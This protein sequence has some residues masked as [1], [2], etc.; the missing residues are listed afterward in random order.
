MRLLTVVVGL[1]TLGATACSGS[2]AQWQP[3]GVQDQNPG[4]TTPVEGAPVLTVS[5]AADATNVSPGEP[6]TVTMANGTLESVT[7]TNPDN[8]AVKGEIDA[9]KSTWKL[10][11]QLGYNKKYTLKI[12]AVGGDGSRKEET[13]S[14]T[15]VKPKNLTLPYLRANPGQLLD[16]GKFGTGQPIVAW[17][18][19]AIT[20]KAAAE[21]SLTVTTSPVIEGAWHWMDSHE[22]HWRP[23]EHWPKDTTVTVEAKVYGKDLGGGLFGQ[24]DVTAKFTIGRDL[25]LVADH[26]T[27]HMKVY[28]DGVQM[29]SM[30]GQNIT[31][32]IPIS[33]GKGGTEK[34]SNGQIIDFRTNSGPH[35]VMMKYDN[36]RMTSASFGI[37]NPSSPNFYD[38]NIPLAMRITG[39]GEFVHKRNWS[40]SQ[41]GNLNTSH[42]CINVG[43]PYIRWLYDNMLPGDIVDVKN[44]GKNLDLRNGLGDWMLSWEDWKKG[45]ALAAA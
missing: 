44:T 20:D 18:D 16:G 4:D 43:E 25:L 5:L 29:T 1:L 41:M 9:S 42:G 31:N 7:L 14:F 35:V 28:V 22:V 19:E 34:G 36:Y 24:D 45:S 26:D 30:A 17:F 3:P 8:K 23:K 6:I 32:G 2:G 38:A 27:K 12:V 37:T 21:R 11:E 10:G 39:D 15:T 33:M 40:V 13:R